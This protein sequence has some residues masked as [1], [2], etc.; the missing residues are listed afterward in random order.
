MSDQGRNCV[1]GSLWGSRVAGIDSVVNRGR[2]EVGWNWDHSTV[3]KSIVP[4]SNSS[5]N[6]SHLPTICDSRHFPTCDKVLTVPALGDRI[7]ELVNKRTALWESGD[8]LTALVPCEHV[9][10]ELACAWV[11]HGPVSDQQ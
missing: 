2:V 1:F 10:Q 4:G 5:S 9:L 8:T 3:I 7:P 6:S 11:A